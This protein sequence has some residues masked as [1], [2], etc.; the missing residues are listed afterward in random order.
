MH[1]G[2]EL[3]VLGEVVLVEGVRTAIGRFG[4]S[5]RDLAASDLGAAVIREVLERTQVPHEVIGDVI[6]GCVGQVAEDAYI[7]RT[8]A[9]KAG[10]PKET[11]AYAVNR[12]CSSGLQSIVSAGHLIRLGEAD[13]VIAGGTE[14]MSNAPYFLRKARWGYRMGHDALEDGLLT[15]LNDPFKKY[16]MGVT[17][18]NVAEKWGISRQRQDEVAYQSQMRMARAM[19]N[20]YFDGQIVPVVVRDKRE[21]RVFDKD[22]HPRPD[23]T[24]ERLA[25]MKPVFKEGGTVTAGNA[26]GINDGAAAVLVMSEE[27]AR[28]LGLKPRLVLR[29]AAAAGVDPEYMGIGPVPAVRKALAK[30]GL[31]L[32]DIDLIELNEAFAAQ[33]EAVVRDLDMDWERVNVNGGAI[34]HGHPVGATGAILTVKLMYEMERRRAKYGMVTLCIGGGQGLAVIFENPNA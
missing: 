8:S 12:L 24:L 21:E 25:Q 13:A 18:E 7:A 9:I 30:A 33:A 5:L 10:L 22:E 29:A 19:E 6:F 23:T 1:R 17:A 32:D 3:K 16:H 14:S 4:G 27:K 26:S 34:A 20:G 11:P 31:T 15:M 28:E 2:W